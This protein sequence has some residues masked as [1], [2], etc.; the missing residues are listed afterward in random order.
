MVIVK[1]MKLSQDVFRLRQNVHSLS[2]VVLG[3]CLDCVTLGYA[4]RPYTQVRPTAQ[5]HA[6]VSKYP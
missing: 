1:V 3:F 2:V 4:A 6:L 5:A